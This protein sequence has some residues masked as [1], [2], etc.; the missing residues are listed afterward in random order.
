MA[1]PMVVSLSCDTVMIFTDRLFVSRLGTSAMNAV[2]AGGI[3]AFVAQT[4]FGGL[5]GYSTALVAQEY[6]R[7]QHAH[8][9]LATYQA[10]LIALAAWP[11]TLLMLLGGNALFPRLG[12]PPAQL[13]DQIRYFDLIMLG[14][15]IGLLRGALSGFFSGL[16]RTRVVMLA[17]L[18]SMLVNI[19]LV[20]LFVFGKFG[21]PA[22]GVT[23]AAIGTLCASALGTLTLGVAFL[24]KHGAR[25]FGPLPRFCLHRPLMSELVRKGASS[26]G[27]F[28]LNMVAFQ[29]MVLMFQRH[30][31]ASA[32]AAS[33]LFSWDMVTFVPLVGVEIGVTSLVGRYVGARNF[34][35]ARRSL[36]SGLKLGWLFSSLVLLA[37][38]A[39][40]HILVDV[41]RSESPTDAFVSGRQLAINM[42]RVAAI[43]IGAEA[44]LVVFAGALRGAGDTLYTMLATV[45]MHWT[46][47]LGLW[48]TL[49]V[50]HLSP[51]YGWVV[52][53]G[54][55]TVF[56]LLLWQRWR[57]GL[58]RKGVA[59]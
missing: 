11:A 31:E 37:F 22:L 17:S 1:L 49:E 15:G 34:A 4:F 3:S 44:V 16:G 9:V 50:L 30:S 24:S 59:L 42:I 55:F 12:L 27:E 39:F 2:F 14:S 45:M 47:V 57:T 35:G 20:W 13:A 25:R 19:P 41:F 33:I 28:F 32:T 53:V 7:K 6:G 51:L 40:P 56:P 36:R 54:I 58:W 23:G 46:S 10:I 8:C 5:I 43:Y 21:L 18:L 52:L 38:V 26:G 48:L 29:A